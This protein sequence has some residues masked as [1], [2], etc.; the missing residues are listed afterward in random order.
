[1]HSISDTF[2][3]DSAEDVSLFSLLDSLPDA[4][5]LIDPSG[6]IVNINSIFA[7]RLGKKPSECIGSNIFELISDFVMA[8]GIYFRKERCTEVLRTGKHFVFEERRG[9]QH[10]NIILSP[11]KSPKGEVTHLLI[12]IQDITEKQHIQEAAAKA[13]IQTALALELAHTGIWE[14]DLNTGENIWSDSTWSLYGLSRDCEMAT[15]ELW[16]RT[17]HPD[18]REA[19]VHMIEAAVKQDVDINIE[20]RVYHLDGSIH[21]L[22]VRGIPLRDNHARVDRYIGIVVDITERKHAETELAKFQKHMNFALEKSHV[23]VWD[24]NLNNT[25]VKRTLEHARIFGYEYIVPGWTL[26]MFLDHIVPDDRHAIEALIRG[27]INNHQDYEFECRIQPAEGE[28]RWIMATGAFYVDKSSDEKHVLGIVQDVTERKRSEKERETLQAQL[29]HSQKLEVIGQ[30]AG[31]IAHDFNNH[32]TAILGYIELAINEVSETHPIAKYIKTI[33][34]SALRS[35]ELTHK[36]LAFARKQPVHPKVLNLN[37]EIEE[38]LPILGQLVHRGIEIEWAPVHNK[39]LITID[40]SQSDQILTNLCVNARDAITGAGKI[41]ITTEIVEIK[42]EEYATKQI[43]QIPG[44]YVKLAVTDTGCG[45]ETETLPHIF[46]PFFTTKEIGKGTGLGLS[47]VYGIVKQNKGYI[48]CKSETGQ[49]TTFTLWLH[50]YDESHDVRLITNPEKLNQA[51]K[52]TILLVE[53]EMD[54]LNLVK[55]ILEK[56]EFKVFSASDA[57]QAL[58]IAAKNPYQINLLLTDV[59]LPKM[60][61]IELSQ[62]LHAEYPNMKTLFMSGYTD[63]INESMSENDLKCTFISKPFTFNDLLDSVDKALSVKNR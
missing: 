4:V 35:A 63:W 12:I 52:K 14:A 43:G 37:M 3:A 56:K 36:L 60:N 9:D 31:G 18:D 26:E 44:H 15:T 16:N 50:Q 46:E 55:R 23:G 58:E 48:D 17:V 62:R 47:T 10:L 30:L 7:G 21:W 11:V 54:V 28:V 6:R 34:Q 53:D 59:R 5:S 19:A 2:F 40:P 42:E 32:L 38:M 8:E 1:M 29:L 20:Y 25:T 22:M 49:G 61:G 33:Q 39:A 27:S 13:K 41:T 51:E 45:I 57:E 24:L